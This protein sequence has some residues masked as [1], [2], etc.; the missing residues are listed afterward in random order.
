MHPLINI[1]DLWEAQSVKSGSVLMTH[2]PKW[3]EKRAWRH[4]DIS[5]IHLYNIKRAG[6]RRK[7][8]ILHANTAKHHGSIPSSGKVN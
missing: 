8:I 3:P 6:I 5:G 1:L 2:I 7:I 4:E